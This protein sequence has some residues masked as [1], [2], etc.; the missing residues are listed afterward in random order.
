MNLNERIQEKLKIINRFN[1]KINIMEVCGTHTMA[2]SKFGLRSIL[3]ENINLVSGPGCPVCVT[4][5]SYIDY[6]YDI[7]MKEDVIVATYG[8]MIRV[9]GSTPDISLENAKAKGAQVKIVYSSIDTI[10]I[11]KNNLN[12]TVVFLGV[13]FETTTPASA[14]LIKEAFRNNLSNLKLLSTHKIVEPVMKSLLVD[15]EL[16]IDGFL[17]PGH[18]A[19]IIGEEGFKFL[20]SYNCTG[21]ITGFEFEE[22]LDAI[23]VLLYKIENRE[24]SIGNCYKGLVTVKGNELA[25]DLI[26]EVFE[27]TED[28]W[29]GIGVIDASGLKLKSKYKAFDIE[30]IYPFDKEKYVNKPTACQCGDVLKG[31]IKPSECRLFGKVCSPENPV[32]PC[33]VS[34]EGSCSAYYKYNINY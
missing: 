18:V 21:V 9:P 30:N 22:I 31:K 32:G 24:Y 2:I 7:A 1:R 26:N 6:M 3:S 10:E 27:V 23:I 14:I 25:M 8:D 19:T 5:S 12:K 17:C 20:N 29:R 11:A 34:S 16:K 33:M 28:E 4:P 15:P 13:G